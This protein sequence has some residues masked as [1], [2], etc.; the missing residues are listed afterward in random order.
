MQTSDA[1]ADALVSHQIGIQRLSNATV[2]K[3]LAMLK[4]S[5]ARIVERLLRDGVTDLSRARQEA[6]LRD[7]RRIIGSAYKDATGALN[8]QLEDLAKYEAEYQANLFKRIVPIDVDFIR[9]A[10][11]QLIAAVNTRPFQG[12]LLR[13]WFADLDAK[14]FERLRNTIRAGIVE[15]RTLAQM[16]AEIRGTAANGYK[17]GVLHINRR[18]AEA[19][20][21]TAVAHTNNIARSYTYERNADIIKGVQWVST[22]DG[23]TSAICRG[24][25]GMVFKVDK[26]PRPPAH[27]NCR[28]S[29]VPVLKSWREL[30]IDRKDLPAGT[31]A[32]MNGEVP[33]DINY[34][35]WLRKQPLTVQN[36]VLG[37]RKAQ[38]FR[39]G[40]VGLE[41][42]INRAGDELTLDEL[43]RKESAAWEKAFS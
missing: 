25:D 39:K 21:R 4:R 11:D 26:G 14:S 31:R 19:T 16:V 42:F 3:L 40:G 24:R 18:A 38:L 27:P 32:S 20:V 37:I 36:D 10:A 22:L 23:R 7:I 43:K 9:P 41:R 8:I 34:S 13:E 5:D 30:G 6:M 2:R 29:T 28:S 33:A 1:I 17:D 15:G 12:R 35:D